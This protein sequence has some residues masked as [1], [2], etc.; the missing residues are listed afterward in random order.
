LG[1]GNA[2]KD[3]FLTQ[4]KKQYEGLSNPI[5]GEK[6]KSIYYFGLLNL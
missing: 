1:A 4:F 6:I 5:N 3:V 2:E